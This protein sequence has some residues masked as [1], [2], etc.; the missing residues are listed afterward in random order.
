MKN[1]KTVL[2]EY[3]SLRDFKF[4]FTGI[5]HTPEEFKAK[6]LNLITSDNIEEININEL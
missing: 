2:E 4:T 6:L 3:E 1:L 5:F